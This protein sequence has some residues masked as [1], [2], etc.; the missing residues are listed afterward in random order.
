M[1]LIKDGL[2]FEVPP[3]DCVMD[4]GDAQAQCSALPFTN[5][6][7]KSGQ[8]ASLDCV[9]DSGQG[10]RYFFPVIYL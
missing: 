8:H 7:V 5:R 3:T 9:K 10:F 1:S 4:S 6:L 2:K